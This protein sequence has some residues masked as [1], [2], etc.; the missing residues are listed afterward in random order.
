[1]VTRTR[2]AS[3]I[4]LCIVP[5]FLAAWPVAA[6]AQKSID[7]PMPKT[8]GDRWFAGAYEVSCEAV[9][10]RGNQI[11][12]IFSI[13]R[14]EED[15]L[16]E[17]R[18]NAVRAIVFRGVQTSA[19]DVPALLRPDDFSVEA[20]KYFDTFFREGGAYLSYVAFAGD[21][22]ESQVRVGKQVK[23]G[24]TVVVQRERLRRDLESAGILSSM[25]GIFD[26]RRPPR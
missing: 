2:S 26:T 15:A 3:R 25:A 6:V 17:A 10:A 11:L 21:E 7:K 9:A 24:T 1:M 23:I 19:C 14:N 20:D 4:V 8:N 16:R 13:G 12:Q 22:V 5:A 18:R